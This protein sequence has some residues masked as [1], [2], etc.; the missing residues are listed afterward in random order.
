MGGTRPVVGRV[1]GPGALRYIPGRS[2]VR[3]A[4][5]LAQMPGTLFIVSAPSGAGKTSLVRTLLEAD[6]GIRLS[7]SFTTRAPR[8]GEVEGLH[9]QFLDR[10]TFEAMRA[11][12]EFLESAE[13]HGNFYGTGRRWVENRLAEGSDILLEIDWQGAAQ[14]RR[15]APEAV[16]VF[17]LP[18]SLETLAQR[19]ALRAT[20]SDAVISRRLEAARGEIAH[21]DEFDY[22]ILNKDFDVASADLRAIVRSER[23]RRTAQLARHRDL[24]NRMK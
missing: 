16:T 9:Y 24:I 11:R 3:S 10:N 23:L 14:V 22:V 5:L 6:P 21:V 18:P 2:D 20:D 13:V 15:L 12:G 17:I 19:L 1:R 4:L 8:P 7:V